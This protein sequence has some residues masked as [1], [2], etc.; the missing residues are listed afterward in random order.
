MTVDN[1]AILCEVQDC[2]TSN[3]LELYSLYIELEDLRQPCFTTF[4]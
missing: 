1:L 4:F 2:W 3:A